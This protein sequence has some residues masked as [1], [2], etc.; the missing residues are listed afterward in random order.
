V[1]TRRAKRTL[2][3]DVRVADRSQATDDFL[4]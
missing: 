4:V 3:V 2:P 1:R